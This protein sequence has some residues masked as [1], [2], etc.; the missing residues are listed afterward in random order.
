MNTPTLGKAR[1]VSSKSHTTSNEVCIPERI[2][3]GAD[4]GLQFEL[5]ASRDRFCRSRCPP[6]AREVFSAFLAARLW[7]GRA[8]SQGFQPIACSSR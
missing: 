6:R 7:S 2:E 4:A 5:E 8:R 1:F 3:V